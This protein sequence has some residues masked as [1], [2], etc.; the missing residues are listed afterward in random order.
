[1][2][3]FFGIAARAKESPM[4]PLPPEADADGAAL[5][6]AELAAGVLA[7]AAGLLAWAA[8]ELAGGVGVVDVVPL[9]DDEE[10]PVR[11]SAAVTAIKPLMARAFTG[12]PCV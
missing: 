8:A 11:T 1:M 3:S 6:D 12:T 2:S 4:K 5:D 10:H 7:T 9:L